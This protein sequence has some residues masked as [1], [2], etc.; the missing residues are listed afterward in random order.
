MV[1]LIDRKVVKAELASWLGSGT[2]KHEPWE[3]CR[4]VVRDPWN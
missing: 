2:R 1:S 4:E 3:L